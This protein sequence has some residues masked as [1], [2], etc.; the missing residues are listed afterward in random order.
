MPWAGAVAVFGL[1]VGGVALTQ[2]RGFALAACWLIALGC[3]SLQ[4]GVLR[5][6]DSRITPRT[7]WRP[8]SR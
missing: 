5:L 4:A 2:A 6:P 3:A 7:L 8:S 1:H